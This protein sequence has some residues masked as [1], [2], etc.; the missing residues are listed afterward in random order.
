MEVILFNG[1]KISMSYK[2]E[3]QEKE[4]EKYFK[5]FPKGYC[6]SDE[7]KLK[8]Y[9]LMRDG[10]YGLQ[11]GLDKVKEDIDKL[12][13]QDNRTYS[14]IRSHVSSEIDKELAVL[15]EKNFFDIKEKKQGQSSNYS[16]KITVL[17]DWKSLKS[18]I[19]S[20][21]NLTI[22]NPYVSGKR[23]NVLDGFIRLKR[24][25]Y[26][27]VIKK[28]LLSLFPIKP[29]AFTPEDIELIIKEVLK[30]YNI[31]IKNWQINSKDNKPEEIIE[32]TTNVLLSKLGYW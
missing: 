30:N 13:N 32:K 8:L 9:A 21:F 15:Y 28:F 22:K 29:V 23:I 16:N 4:F 3:Y 25:F 14:I 10:T 18:S 31:E 26:E 5:H 1:I 24:E 20:K 19:K 2:D 27:A 12:R 7:V 11:E 17:I 6:F